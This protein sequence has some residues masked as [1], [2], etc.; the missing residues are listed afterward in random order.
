MHSRLA[1]LVVTLL[2]V[3]GVV[4]LFDGAARATADQ[5]VLAVAGA[6]FRVTTPAGRV[7]AQSDLVGAILA[8]SVEGATVEGRIA[9]V[10]PDPM[11]PE[12]DV[13]LYD[14]RVA[15][16]DGAER[17]LCQAGPDGIAAGFPIAGRL[18]G[19]GHLVPG[20]PQDFE[21]VCTAGARGKCVRFGYRPWAGEA[22]GVS[23]RDLYN[24]CV[25][26]VRADFCGDG[27]GHTENGTL[28]GFYDTG[29]VNPRAEAL[30]EDG[31]SELSFEAAWTTDGAA[32][33]AKPRLA[34]LGN[35]DDL[36]AE[37]P[38]LAG[39]TGREACRPGAG[40]LLES[41]SR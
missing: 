20:G 40:G 15:G 3:A 14:V 6:V 38:R 8:L 13:M 18:D 24:A 37:C 1:L 16:E 33:V 29:G 30:A 31:W 11:V 34:R 5:P 27:R 26:M 23:M 2:G 25:H 9:A 4:A 21:F 32:C 36:V 17:P 39:R 7:V 41:W 35:L 19:K 22:G 12:G 10:S 28:I